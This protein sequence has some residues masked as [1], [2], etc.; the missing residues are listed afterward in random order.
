MGS[1]DIVFLFGD[2]KPKKDHSKMVHR[3][4]KDRRA[5][6]EWRQQSIVPL[7]S[8]ESTEKQYLISLLKNGEEL[9]LEEVYS[10][11]DY[12][13]ILADGEE[14]GRF[15]KEYETR[16]LEEGAHSAYLE[17]VEED[18]SGNLKPYL[19]VY[20]LA[21]S[22][23]PKHKPEYKLVDARSI[24]PNTT[25]FNELHPLYKKN[26]IFTG[27]LSIEREDAMQSAAN[28]GAILKNDIS[29]KIDYLVVGEKDSEFCDADGLSKKERKAKEL[30]ENGKGH[31]QIISDAEFMKLLRWKPED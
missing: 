1:T 26:I 31:I 9:H 20:W 6:N 12:V 4:R 30:I 17:R 5:K 29:R 2:V 13:E 27:K 7:I 24:T 18:E 25:I 11:I 21:D 8:Y 22:R 28:V 10:D 16:C 23:P 15:P 14:I 3:Y 19:H